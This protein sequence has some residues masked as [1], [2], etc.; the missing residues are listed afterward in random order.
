MK[1]LDDLKNG[2]GTSMTITTEKNIRETIVKL[3]T[4]KIIYQNTLSAPKKASGTPLSNDDK[5]G[6]RQTPNLPEGDNVIPKI[7]TEEELKIKSKNN[8]EGE[9]KNKDDNN[10]D[11]LMI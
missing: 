8:N 10:D 9:S 3:K 5:N 7:D 6:K 11:I 1:M 2:I 4:L